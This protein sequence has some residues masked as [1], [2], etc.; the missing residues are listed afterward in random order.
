[1]FGCIAAVF[2]LSPLICHAQQIAPKWQGHVEAEGKW[3]NDRSIG[4]GGLF[5]PVWQNN[6]TLLFTDLRGRFDNHSSDEGNFGLGLRREAGRG[7]I[8]GGYGFYDS[9][10]TPSG[11]HFD[12]ATFGAEAMSETLEFRV[13]AYIPEA[14]EKDTGAGS[15]VADTS[16]GN[17]EIR[18]YS[19]PKERALP[20]ADIEAGHKF[21]LPGNW[22]IWAYGGGF[23]FGADGYKDIVGPRGRLELSYNHVPY[24]GDG[25]RLTVGVEVQHDSVRGTQEFG[26]ARLR[27]PFD[28]FS[29][30]KQKA[31][32]A[33]ELSALDQRMTDRIYRDVDIVGGAKAA[34]VVSTEAATA[35]LASGTQV[36]SY[37]ALDAHDN[38]AT[39]IPAAGADKLIVLDGSAGVINVGSQINLA[40]GQTIISG[41]GKI[42]LT[43]TT[44][45]KTVSATMPGT[46][47]TVNGT[48]TSNDVFVSNDSNVVLKDFNITG[49]RIQIYAASGTDGLTASDM[50]LTGAY[51]EG[52]FLQYA[53]HVTAI[54]IAIANTSRNGIVS[55]DGTSDL[56]FTNVTV[57]HVAG[58][59]F[60]NWPMDT[61]NGVSGDITATNYGVD[62]CQN[63]GFISSSTLY[64]NGV[65]CH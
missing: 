24:L 39:A 57:D 64:V 65:L 59:G 52:L 41:G 23:Y 29:S 7:W 50:N 38:L 22:D 4:E 37:T 3:G 8:L 6:D 25:S 34:H 20:G 10:R 36:S 42:T 21:K 2:L 31:E 17:I 56:T 11:N 28:V 51:Y 13:N 18:N 32:T 55:A 9:R 14:T 27:I 16:G 1:L 60:V 47:A 33:H 58:N 48:S 12:Q 61:I 35:T 62:A 40:S 46:T 43:G 63:G 53:S 30:R 26:I 49:G 5:I 44:T 54:N 15:S 45:G 19:A